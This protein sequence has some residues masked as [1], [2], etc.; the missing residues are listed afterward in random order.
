MEVTVYSTPGCLYCIRAKRLLRRR[1]IE[2]TDVSFSFFARDAR[3]R[4]QSLSGG[5]RTFPQIVIDGVA[6]GGCDALHALD[7]AGG[8]TP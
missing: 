7:R 8:L 1:G 3:E 6:I 2:F 4:M 5:G